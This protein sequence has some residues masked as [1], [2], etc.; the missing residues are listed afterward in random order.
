MTRPKIGSQKF[1]GRKDKTVL[2]K[3]MFSDREQ[4]QQHDIQN[5]IVVMKKIVA[6]NEDHAIAI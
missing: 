2:G 1:Y 3:D 5:K 6:S 4:M